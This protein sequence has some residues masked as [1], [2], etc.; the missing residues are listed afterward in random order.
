MQASSEKEQPRRG[1]AGLSPEGNWGHRRKGGWR[2]RNWAGFWGY[3]MCPARGGG[4]SGEEHVQGLQW[5]R[6]HR[7]FSSLNLVWFENPDI[8]PVEAGAGPGDPNVGLP[9]SSSGPD[10]SPALWFCSVRSRTLDL[11][12]RMPV[13]GCPGPSSGRGVTSARVLAP[14]SLAGSRPSHDVI[15]PPSLASIFLSKGFIPKHSLPMC[16]QDGSL[17]SKPRKKR[18]PFSQY[19]PTK[20]LDRLSL[21]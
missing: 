11:V 12:V 15:G 10:L 17:Q 13:P 19:S 2:P 7:G 8:L 14:V 3:A 16:W 1:L 9:A 6:G 20:F 4:N 5:K 21:A 18:A